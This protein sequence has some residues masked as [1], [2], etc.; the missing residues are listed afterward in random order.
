MNH[1]IERPP[2]QT[3]CPRCTVQGTVDVEY[4][5]GRR[6]RVAC[7]LCGF[8]DTFRAFADEFDLDRP[9]CQASLAEE[10]VAHV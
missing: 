4:G 7:E 2:T 8:A 9:T 3:Q 6:Q 1:P 10:V 5:E